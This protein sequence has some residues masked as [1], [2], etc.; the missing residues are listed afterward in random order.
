M[1]RSR[2]LV[3]AT[4]GLAV[5]FIAVLAMALVRAGHNGPAGEGWENAGSLEE[6]D[7]TR[8]VKVPDQTVYLV[9]SDLTPL[10]LSAVDPHLGEIIAYCESSGWFEDPDHGSKYDGQGY[11]AMGP[12]PRGMDRVAVTVFQ[13]DVWIQP[14]NDTEG[15]P[16]GADNPAHEDPRG[17]FCS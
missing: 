6:L 1:K 13:G 12:S 10:A 7:A 8:V 17:P 4:L 11:Y 9:A 3:A 16:R 15:P 14:A 2:I 5:V